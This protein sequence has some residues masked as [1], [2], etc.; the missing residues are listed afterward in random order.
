MRR[1]AMLIALAVGARLAWAADDPPGMSPEARPVPYDSRGFAPDPG[2]ADKPYDIEE[3]LRIYGGKHAVPNPRPLLELGRPMYQ[4]GP[5][6]AGGTAFGRKNPTAPAFSVYGDWRSAMARNNN[7]GGPVDVLATRLNLDM[8]WKLTATERLH[9]FFR[10]LDHNTEFTR[11]EH[12][13]AFSGTRC[14]A[15]LDAKPET[16]FFEGDLGAIASGLRDRY[17]AFDLPFAV[18]KIPLL[19]QNG[20]WLED[21]FTGF[22]ATLPARNSPR[23]GISNMDVTFFAGFDDVDSG[24]VRDARGGVANRDAHVYGVTSFIEANRGYWELGYAYTQDRSSPSHDQSYHN[25]AAAFTRRYGGWLS[26]SVRLIQNFGQEREASAPRTAN[27]TLLL[28]ENSL[29]TRRPLTLVPYLNLFFGHDRPQSVARAVD[30]GGILKNTGVNFETDGLTGFPRLDDTANNTRGGALGVEYLFDL[31]QQVVV[32]IATVRPHGDA[33]RTIAGAQSA[34]GVRYQ[35]N[36]SKAW[37]L[38]ADA[39]ALDRQNARDAGGVRFE[40]RRKF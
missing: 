17:S 3:Q 33:A 35:R 32:E 21:A 30:A 28:I 6:Q 8:D 29:V 15:E 2:Y 7:G 27:G 18:G 14:E 40:L 19:L 25:V 9:A 38:R 10:P 24:G 26:N 11:C 1:L 4:G 36:L 12:S 16:L 22:A 5:L 23:L 39:I 34:L 13:S 37:L 20:V 31:Q